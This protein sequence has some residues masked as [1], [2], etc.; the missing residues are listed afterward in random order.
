VWPF[1]L[2]PA[3]LVAA[4]YVSLTMF[5]ATFQSGTLW[6]QLRA[7]MGVARDV[8]EGGGDYANVSAWL[9]DMQLDR[10]A[11]PI[12]AVAF[13][14]LGVWLYR[15]RQTDLCVRLGVVALVTRFWLYHR[16]YDDVI[17]VLAFVALFRIWS[18]VADGADPRGPE[19]GGE[20]MAY[21]VRVRAGAAALLAT[22]MFFMLLPA[23]LGTSQPPW[24]QIFDVSHTVT[25]LGLLAF[26][27]WYASSL[28]MP[29]RGHPA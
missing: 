4:G 12:A 1:R 28:R 6:S 13:M 20:R 22:S 15:H 23:R 10:L 21:D 5:A 25:W 7:W 9:G 27:A 8:A 3:V 16:V 24:R 19:L 17:V 11:L 26:L 29:S 2:R 18:Q 14:A